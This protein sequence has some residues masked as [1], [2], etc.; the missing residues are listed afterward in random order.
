MAVLRVLV[1]ALN[2]I[3]S[4]CF[5]S[6]IS[7]TALTLFSSYSR[8]K[9]IATFA[10]SSQSTQSTCRAALITQRFQSTSFILLKSG[11]P[12]ALSTGSP[13]LRTIPEQPSRP[14]TYQ[15]ASHLAPSVS[16]STLRTGRPA[17]VLQETLQRSFRQL[18]P[19]PVRL[20]SGWI[21]CGEL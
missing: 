15:K 8:D 7:F 21:N 10:V 4:A 11:P 19:E 17:I 2:I 14:L 13:C 1:I 20:A 3:I 9:G 18:S 16:A 6:G 5:I 12:A